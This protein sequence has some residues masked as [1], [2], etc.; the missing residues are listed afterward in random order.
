MPVLREHPTVFQRTVYLLKAKNILAFSTI[1]SAKLVDAWSSV[2]A[3][4]ISAHDDRVN[5]HCDSMYNLAEL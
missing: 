1:E 4:G 2:N 5:L 3:V